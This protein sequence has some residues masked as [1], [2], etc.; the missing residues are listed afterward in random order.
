MF[1]FLL[2]FY[3]SK[4][5]VDKTQRSSQERLSVQI[6]DN[7]KESDE[8]TYPSMWREIQQIAHPIT[9]NALKDFY[10]VK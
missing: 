1:D 9:F 2:K 8:L 4:N 10:K 5:I 6:D 3:R 7:S